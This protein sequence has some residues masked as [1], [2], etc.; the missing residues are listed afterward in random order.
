MMIATETVAEMAL[1][2]KVDGLAANDAARSCFTT[3]AGDYVVALNLDL[4]APALEVVSTG[5][6]LAVRCI[7]SPAAARP[8]H[9]S[10]RR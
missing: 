3:R 2:G 4:V 6:V 8:P 10:A 1:D 7:S 9:R 5:R